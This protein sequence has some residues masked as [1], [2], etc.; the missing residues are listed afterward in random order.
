MTMNR[1]FLR[2][3]AVSFFLCLTGSLAFGQSNR[4]WVSA[5]AGVTDPGTCAAS[6]ICTR[7]APCATF[8]CALQATNAGGEIDALDSGDFGPLNG[9]NSITKSVSIVADGVVAGIQVTSSP[10]IVVG[11]SNVVV[12]LR[13]LTL[14]G[15]SAASDGIF[16]KP[17]GGVLHIEDC[18]INRFASRGISVNPEGS[19]KVFI[20]DS[21]VRNNNAGIIFEQPVSGATVTASLDNVRIENNTQAVLAE[22]NTTVSVRNSVAAGNTTGFEASGS[23][24]VM[25]LESTIVSGNSS[26]GIL[27]D[28]A[29]STINITN[30][31]VVKNGTGLSA[32]NGGHIVSF[33]N[34]KIT[35]NT[36]NGSPTKTISQK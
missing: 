16:F 3:L 35:N 20:K 21:I 33:G 31:T 10:A 28:G 26:D 29:N 36:T 2:G 1:M 9:A 17:D 12:V 11:G 23:P 14:D 6:N 30:V 8:A 7:S 4:T 22:D 5:A 32:T 25:N 27:S 24:V 18:T 34:N 15:T 19:D 13:G